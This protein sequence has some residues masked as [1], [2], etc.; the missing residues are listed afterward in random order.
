VRGLMVYA[1]LAPHLNVGG[2]GN[3]ARRSRVSGQNLLL[4]WKDRTYL[5]MG[6]NQGFTKSSCGYVGTSDGWQDISRN[7]KLNWEFERAEDGNVALIGEI[8]LA[9]S[10]EFTLGIAFGDGSTPR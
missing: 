9:H 5:A 6:T 8:D 3:S 7:F 2:W 1:L 10:K 4:A